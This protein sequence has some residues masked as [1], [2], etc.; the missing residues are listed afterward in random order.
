[1]FQVPP[2]A[3][4]W[5]A[6]DTMNKNLCIRT[7]LELKASVLN[8]RKTMASKIH[9]VHVLGKK[10]ALEVHIVTSSK[11]KYPHMPPILSNQ[12]KHMDIKLKRF[13]PS[14][15]GMLHK[16]KHGHHDFI[17][18][19]APLN[20]RWYQANL[21]YMMPRIQSQSKRLRNHHNN[22]LQ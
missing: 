19:I 10:Y 17:H 5:P 6:D 22:H 13:P 7:A 16:Q 1:V 14:E 3:M 21:Q 18:F 8:S 4:G 11:N 9:I 2:D 20:F 15:H 12:H